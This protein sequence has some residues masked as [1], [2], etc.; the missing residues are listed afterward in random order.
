MVNENYKSFVEI[1]KKDGTYADK[2][3]NLLLRVKKG[4][5]LSKGRDGKW[6]E[7]VTPIKYP[8]KKRFL[9]YSDRQALQL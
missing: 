2:K 8:N 7:R 3:A 4:V 6:E 5:V 9:R 1:C